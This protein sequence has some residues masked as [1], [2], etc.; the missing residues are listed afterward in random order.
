MFV[1]FVCLL[2]LLV[3]LF[4][5]ITYKR[6]S[7]RNVYKC[8]LMLSVCVWLCV[9][10]ISDSLPFFLTNNLTLRTELGVHK[11]ESTKLFLIDTTDDVVRHWG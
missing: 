8:V 6:L 1:L 9:V 5:F 11:R 7:A 10:E 2:V 3:L 4:G